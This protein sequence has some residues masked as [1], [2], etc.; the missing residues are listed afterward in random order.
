MFDMH[1][2]LMLLGALGWLK[3]KLLKTTESSHFQFEH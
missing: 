1:V 2:F 3:V